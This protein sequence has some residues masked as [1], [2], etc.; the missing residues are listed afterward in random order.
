MS[1]LRSLQ[2]EQGE[3]I[4]ITIGTLPRDREWPSLLGTLIALQRIRVLTCKVIHGPSCIVTL[5]THHLPALKASSLSH[6]PQSCNTGLAAESIYCW[7]PS[8]ESLRRLKQYGFSNAKVADLISRYQQ[9]KRAYDDSQFLRFCLSHEKVAAQVLSIPEHWQPLPKTTTD[10]LASGIPEYVIAEYLQVFVRQRQSSLHA[11]SWDRSFTT[12]ANNLWDSD[13][14]NPYATKASFMGAGW[15]PQADVMEALIADGHDVQSLQILVSEYRLYWREAGV[16][17]VG[18][19]RHF[20]WWARTRKGKL[21]ISDGAI[22]PV[23]E[24][25]AK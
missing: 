9:E 19:S 24:S 5:L 25:A 14:R 16:A 15:E 11:A 17:K 13:N 6:E 8:Q 18:W 4:N 10:L 2:A 23:R 1:W 20:L 12:M 7:R 22:L 21:G 3:C